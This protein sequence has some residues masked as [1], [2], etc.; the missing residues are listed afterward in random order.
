MLVRTHWYVPVRRQVEVF[1]SS[2]SEPHHFN[3][4]SCQ[5]VEVAEDARAR[6]V[7]TVSAGADAVS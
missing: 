2:L 5:L 7:G 1:R 6:G 4:F 3:E